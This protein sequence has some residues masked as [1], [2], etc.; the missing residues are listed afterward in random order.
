MKSHVFY[1]SLARNRDDG[2]LYSLVAN[3]WRGKVNPDVAMVYELD[4]WNEARLNSYLFVYRQLEEAQR[5]VCELIGYGNLSCEIY[6]CLAQKVCLGLHAGPLDVINS[7]D[8]FTNFWNSFKA[9]I[10]DDDLYMYLQCKK[11]KLLERVH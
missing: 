11:L 5:S 9:N 3:P 1:K 8:K 4:K 10:P 7:E 6:K 2:K